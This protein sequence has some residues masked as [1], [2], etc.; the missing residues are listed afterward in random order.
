M[1]W[2]GPGPRRVAESRFGGDAV[3]PT[4]LWGLSPSEWTAIGTIT[5]TVVGIATVV[6]NAFA[7]R[8]ARRSATAA[9]AAAKAAS[10]A[11]GAQLA[12]VEVGFNV[13]LDL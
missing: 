1:M 8:H 10:E 7:V 2:E 5:L 6:V 3:V 11:A 9:E 12:G 13:R 4:D